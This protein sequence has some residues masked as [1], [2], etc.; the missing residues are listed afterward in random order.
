[1]ARQCPDCKIDLRTEEILGIDL[2]ICPECA[3]IFFDDGEMVKLKEQGDDAFGEVDEQVQPEEPFEPSGEPISRMCPACGEVMDEFKYLYTTHIKL[4]SCPK[5]FGTWVEHGELEAMQKALADAE[6]QP[7][8]ESLMRT[9][10]HQLVIAEEEV[11]HQRRLYRQRRMTQVL[12]LL[13]LRRAGP[14]FGWWV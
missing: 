2:D 7:M 12:R 13:T 1:M 10:N 5:C 8:N 6:S 9:L 3:G 11:A 4:D 14:P